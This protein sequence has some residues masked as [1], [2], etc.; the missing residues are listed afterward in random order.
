MATKKAADTG[1]VDTTEQKR[2]NEAR[3]AGI[4]WKKWGPYLSERQWG[5][6]RE[7]YSD[8]R[9]RL[10]LLHARPVPLAGLPVG[11]GRP[12]R[13]LR[14]QAA[15]VLRP[16][17]LERA[18]PDPQGARVR[19][20]QQRGEPRR[21]RQGVLLL[22]RLDADPLVHE[23]P[24]QVPAARVPLPGPRRDE[25][26][27]LEAGARV[28]A[29]RHGGLRRRPVLRRLPRVR[30]GRTGGHPDQGVGPQPGQGGGPAAAAPDAVVPEHLVVGRRG[31]QAG[32]AREGRG[33]RGLSPRAG[34]VH[35]L[36]RRQAGAAVHGE[37]VERREALGP[38][39]PDAVR[40]GRVPPVRDL[41]G[42]GRGEPRRRPGPR[43]RRA[44]SSRCR[45]A[46][47]SSSS[48]A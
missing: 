26:G 30:Q 19:P 13:V 45:R 16:R 9:Q 38:A 4:P 42:E 1:I 48:S 46:G 28:R 32:P 41:R 14:R 40:E 8:G 35:A 43:P 11:R 2:L 6:V 37:R 47:S 39:E 3:E 31:R 12:R 34:R 17:P 27:A 25:P 33:D 36:L 15:P 7:D 5:T 44:T 29:P 23:V 21:G 20:H 24:L 10:G 22:R 18:G